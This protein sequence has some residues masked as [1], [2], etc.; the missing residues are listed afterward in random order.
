MH[1]ARELGYTPAVR[2]RQD[3]VSQQQLMESVG[4]QLVRIEELGES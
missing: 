4:L 1:A 3:A 2:W